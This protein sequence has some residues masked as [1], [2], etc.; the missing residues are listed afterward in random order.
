MGDLKA[1]MDP[2]RREEQELRESGE[3]GGGWAGVD[4]TQALGIQVQ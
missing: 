3:S 1:G 4:Q 2:G